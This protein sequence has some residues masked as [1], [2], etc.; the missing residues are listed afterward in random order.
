MLL[1][2]IEQTRK[3]PTSVR[4]RYAFMGAA[5]VTSI[6]AITW[7]I[8]IPAQFNGL[9]E[10]VEEGQQS[11]S[12][13]A[14]FF[15]DLKNQATGLFSNESEEPV[16]ETASS[17]DASVVLPELHEETVQKIKEKATT[18]QKPQP[19]RVLIATT[20]SSSTGDTDSE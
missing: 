1:N 10:S 18:T 6:I 16:P 11:A 12:A 4:R 17:T 13:F 7:M 5:A 14:G 3:K 19:R 8:S 15:G 9:S 20:S 2:W